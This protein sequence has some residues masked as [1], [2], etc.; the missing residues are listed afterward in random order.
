MSGIPLID[1]TKFKFFIEDIYEVPKEEWLD[2][3]DDFNEFINDY[4]KYRKGSIE[5]EDFVLL[6]KMAEEDD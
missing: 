3:Y 4:E 6:E 2:L 5:Q 1:V